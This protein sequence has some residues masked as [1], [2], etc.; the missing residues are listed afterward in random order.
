MGKITAADLAAPS[1]AER[2]QLAVD[3]WDS[4]LT[5]PDSA[6]PTKAQLGELD[7][8]LKDYRRRP[9]EGSPLKMVKGR[10]LR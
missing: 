6:P 7:R 3:I 8:R 1:V 9:K 5:A 2:I 4:L 10:I